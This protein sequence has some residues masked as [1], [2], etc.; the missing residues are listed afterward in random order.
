MAENIGIGNEGADIAFEESAQALA[1]EVMVNIETIKK[2]A[3]DVLKIAELLKDKEDSKKNLEERMMEAAGDDVVLEVALQMQKTDVE[4]AQDYKYLMSAVFNLQNQINLYMGQS[5]EMVYVYKNSKGEVELWK[6]ENTVEDLTMGRASQK[7]GGEWRGRYALSYKRLTS[8]A[9]QIQNEKYDPS[10]L[11]ATYQ[12]I[13]ER[14]QISKDR[15][16]TSSFIILWNEGNGWQG[17]KVSSEGVLAESYAGFYLNSIVFDSGAETNVRRFMTD[18]PH[19]AIHV[20]NTSGL[21]EGDVTVEG[22]NVQYGIKTRGASALGYLQVI[23]EAALIYQECMSDMPD[24]A[25]VLQSIKQRLH[26]RGKVHLASQLDGKVDEEFEDL[27]KD[28]IIKGKGVF[29]E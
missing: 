14:K 26:E 11:N 21:L 16:K 29:G 3:R 5:V 18:S 8:L 15:N 24:L 13:L 22:S 23:K 25:G 12:D 20:D 10:G 7:K 9:T 19:G 28:L 4:S 27:I 2:S 1:P 6:M 17:V